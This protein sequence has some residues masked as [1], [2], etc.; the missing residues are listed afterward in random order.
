MT[1]LPPASAPS[2][3]PAPAGPTVPLRTVLLAGGGTAGHVSPLL[4]VADALVRTQP[5]VL[6]TAL[7]T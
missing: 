7:G 6:V 5:G 1:S 4:A 2:G 3:S